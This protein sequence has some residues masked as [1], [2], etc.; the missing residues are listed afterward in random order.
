[1]NDRE[2]ILTT[3]IRNLY[4]TQLFCSRGMSELD[5]VDKYNGQIYTHF[6]VNETLPIQV[7]DLV[8]GVTGGI[9][10]FSIGFVHEIH[11]TSHMVIREIGTNRLCNYSNESFKRI[12]GLSETELLEGEQ[13]LF[14]RKLLKA[15]GKADDYW[16][17]FGGT[18][19][20]PENIVEVWI[21]QRYGGLTEPSMPF[22]FTMKWN[23]RMSIKKI[24]ETMRENGYGTREFDKVKSKG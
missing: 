15:F 3:I 7:G 21:R 23:K 18:K 2:R 12:T 17:R 5:F 13:Y 19:F 14:Y 8:I 20:H 24:I 4:T 6:G 16:Y 11:N 10:D 9:A 1:M 22:S